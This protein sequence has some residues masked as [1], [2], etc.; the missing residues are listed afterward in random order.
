MAAKRRRLELSGSKLQDILH[1]GG[2]S[3][4]GLAKLLQRLSAQDGA[5]VHTFRRDVRSAS[6]EE[7]AKREWTVTLKLASGE[8]WQWSLLDPAAT[9]S[10]LVERSRDLQALY[11]DAWRRTPCSQLS[12]WRVV[13]AFNEF[14]PGNKLSLDQGR[15]TMVLSFSF[16]ELGQAAMSRGSSWI[17]FGVAR[18]NMIKQAVHSV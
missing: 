12:P 9:L 1:V 13:V 2:I 11:T 8:E 15:K 6:K 4:N 7:F 18:S 17:T 16:V 5:S 3:Q 14:T 10:T